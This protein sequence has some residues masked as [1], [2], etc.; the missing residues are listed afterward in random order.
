VTAEQPFNSLQSPEQSNILS[1]SLP[2]K[3]KRKSNKLRK[4]AKTA[5]AMYAYKK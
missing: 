5:Y 1:S 3:A 4:E 2:Q